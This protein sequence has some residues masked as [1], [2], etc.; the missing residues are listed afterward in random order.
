V[1]VDKRRNIFCVW[2]EYIKKEKNAVNIIGAIARKQLRMEVFSRI[3][4]VA[5]ERFLEANAER[6]M[7]ALFKMIKANV[8][9]KAF[10]RWRVRTYSNVVQEMNARRVEL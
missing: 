1:Y 7:N 5:R 10:S 3:R 9:T 6:I 8:V 2:A 4:L